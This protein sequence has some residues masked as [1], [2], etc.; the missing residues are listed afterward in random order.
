MALGVTS[1]DDYAL[2]YK[3]DNRLPSS[4]AS[5]YADFPGW[6]KFLNKD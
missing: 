5:R 2:K 1:K 6:P 3:R 4:P